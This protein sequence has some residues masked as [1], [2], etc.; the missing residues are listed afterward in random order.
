MAFGFDALRKPMIST[1]GGR[2]KIGSS[3]LE[4]CVPA[5]CLESDEDAGNKV[6]QHKTTTR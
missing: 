3:Q 2:I 6:A 4:V 1:C 5:K